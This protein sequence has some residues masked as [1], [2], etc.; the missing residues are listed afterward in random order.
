[1]NNNIYLVLFDWSTTDNEGIETYLY[2]HLE[3]A[4]KKVNEIIED[5]CNPDISWVGDEMFDENGEVNEGYDLESNLDDKSAKEFYWYAVDK[6]DHNRHSFINL[7][8]R[9]IH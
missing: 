1:M 8:I 5:E 2:Y 7:F 9:E 3:D 4:L 6:N